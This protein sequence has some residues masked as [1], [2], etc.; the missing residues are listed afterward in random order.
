MKDSARQSSSST[1]NTGGGNGRTHALTFSKVL[2]GRKQPIRGLWVRGHRYYAQLTVENPVNGLK[3]VKRVPLVDKD[4][5]AVATVAQAIAEMGRLKVQRADKNLPTLRRTPRLSEYV[6][7]YLD[8]IQAGQGT[9]KAGSIAKDKSALANWIEHIGQL[10]LDQIK[11]AHINSFITKRLKAGLKPRTCNLDVISLRCCLK[12]ARQDGWIQRLPME[13]F[14]PLKTTTPRRPFFST[15][16]IESICQAALERSEDGSPVTKNGQ[17]FADYVRLLAYSGARRNEA[18]RL[19]WQDVDFDQEQLHIGSDGDTKNSETRTVDFNAKL[20]AHLQAMHKRS[21]QVSQWLFP[22]PQ[23]G[24]RDVPV[25]TFRESLNLVR[26]HAKMPGFHFHD[27]RHHFV[28][29][30]VMSGVDFMT[31]ASWAGHR[32]G[33]VLIGKVY[34]HLANDHKKA[35]AEKLNFEPAVVE[36]AAKK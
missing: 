25:K 32:D 6:I 10:R 26:T 36:K 31:I 19:R 29:M 13:G 28:S 24:K 4:A 12:Q 34:G 22:S 14:K 20:K 27:C 11:P 16:D 21:R 30:A 7:T 18:L 17:Q 9:K 35:M 2:D 5:N 8:F 3:S 1:A 23:R 15:A 33:G